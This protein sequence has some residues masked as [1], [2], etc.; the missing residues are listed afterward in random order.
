MRNMIA[1]TALA[2]A[3]AVA[4]CATTPGEIR[5]ASLSPLA[6]KEYSCAEIAAES[7]R[8]SARESE[9]RAVLEERAEAD[10]VQMGVGMLLLWPTLLWLDGDGVET[11]EYAKLQRERAALMEAAAAKRCDLPRAEP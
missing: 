6:Y 8:V 1:L 10:T 4:G 9:L 5:A 2:V 7:G 11:E 3:V